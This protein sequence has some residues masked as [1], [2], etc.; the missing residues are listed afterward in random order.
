M[1]RRIVFAA[2]LFALMLP[3]TA[4]A[5]PYYGAIDDNEFADYWRLVIGA[6]GAV[7][8]DTQGSPDTASGYPLNTELWLFDSNWYGQYANDDA[9]PGSYWSQLNVGGLTPGGT[10]FL[11]VS[12]YDT[13]PQSVNGAIFND[14]T[15]GLMTATAAGAG[16]PFDQSNWSSPWPEGYPYNGAYT[17]NIDGVENAEPVP[18]PATLT[19]LGVG[20][21]ALMRRAR[22]RHQVA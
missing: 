18:E 11:A 5:A 7:N 4:S 22:K 2:T 6:S 15:T 14:N 1:K 19:L 12:L 16:A 20:A 9:S 3:L 21:A 13:N 17:L 10:Y 8:I